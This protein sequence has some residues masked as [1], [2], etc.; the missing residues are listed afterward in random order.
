M[1]FALTLF[2]NLLLA[3]AALARPTLEERV[4]RRQ[5]GT[6]PRQ[7][8]PLVPIEGPE[9]AEADVAYT[10]NWAGAV[11]DSPPVCVYISHMGPPY[12]GKQAAQ[13]IRL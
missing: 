12:P 9:G 6:S 11:Y 3:A 1:V 13:P 5:T 2:T 8:G 10:T 7:G 4:A